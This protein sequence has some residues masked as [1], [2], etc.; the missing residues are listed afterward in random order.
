M[1]HGLVSGPLAQNLPHT[2]QPTV[3]SQVSRLRPH[4][5]FI[6]VTMPISYQSDI[7][8]HSY[9]EGL[10]PSI[11]TYLLSCY[12]VELEEREGGVDLEGQN[13]IYLCIAF[14]IGKAWFRQAAL[15]CDASVSSS[16]P[17]RKAWMKIP[18]V[19]S[20]QARWQGAWHENR[21]KNRLVH[22]RRHK[23]AMSKPVYSICEQQRRRSDCAS[24]QSNQHLGCSLPR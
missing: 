5:H 23:W 22:L 17:W 6:F 2:M 15:S 3:P 1:M 4:R 20:N 19:T 13:L 7:R 11:T 18:R 8:Q 21:L 16:S 14:S 24:A 12:G 9:F 10:L